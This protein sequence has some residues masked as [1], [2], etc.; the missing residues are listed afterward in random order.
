MYHA[1]SYPGV[2]LPIHMWVAHGNSVACDGQSKKTPPPVAG[3][4][5]SH[6]NSALWE[7]RPASGAWDVD[8]R[9]PQ[10]IREVPPNF[11]DGRATTPHQHHR[12][13]PRLGPLDSEIAQGKQHQVS[14]VQRN[15]LAT[16]RFPILSGSAFR[17]A[18]FA[19]SFII[20]SRSLIVPAARPPSRLF[21]RYP[22]GQHLRRLRRL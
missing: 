3:T 12:R 13:H 6:H 9:P 8:H 1:S 10:T 15:R 18:G 7:G 2:R 14:Q 19:Y 22:E 21:P 4:F 16:S 11:R 5:L 17:P 20:H